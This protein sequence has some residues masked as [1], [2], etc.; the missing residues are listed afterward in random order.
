MKKIIIIFL[1]AVSFTATAQ[2]KTPKTAITPVPRNLTVGDKVPDI[3][4][5]KMYNYKTRTA[6]LRDFK[7]QL[8]VLDFWSINCHG[9]V[10][11]LPRMQALQQKFGDRIV[12]LPVDNNDKEKEMVDFWKRNEHTKNLTIPTVAADN[13]LSKWF[14]YNRLSHEI[15]IYKGVVIGITES[16]Y[17]TAANIQQVLDGKRV[18]WPIKNDFITRVNPK[19]PLL[20][21][22]PLQ[23]P[24]STGAVKYAAVLGYREE[25][26]GFMPGI[27]RDNIRHTVRSYAINLSVLGVYYYFW[28]Q[29]RDPDYKKKLPFYPDPTREIL[30]VKDLRRFQTSEETGE[31]TNVWHKKHEI[32]F[33]SV[34]PDT[35]QNNETI[36][37]AAITDLDYLLG[38]HGRF[39]T[40]KVKCLVLMNNGAK[41]SI[42]NVNSLI[43]RLNQKRQN[44]PIVDS[45]GFTGTKE[46]DLGNASLTDIP[47]IRKALQPYGLDLKEDERELEMF[48]L[49]ETR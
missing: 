13:I 6:N 22:D 28:H 29:M 44:P 39:E 9:C 18:E 45:T 36:C 30:E 23:F 4:I 8:V 11:G 41:D 31:Y 33:E 32:C 38:M 46:P 21:P 34:N 12:I 27:T 24:D 15:W 1:V 26:E 40:R 5:P 20:K 43:Y 3:F 7:G 48:V 2:K 47:A 37:R 17:V 49:T 10:D 42:L 35:G 25:V 16:E 19:K 14:R